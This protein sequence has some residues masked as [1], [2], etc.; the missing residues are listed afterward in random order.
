MLYNR[1]R[2]GEFYIRERNKKNRTTSTGT[3]LLNLDRWSD[4]PNDL[5]ILDLIVIALLRLNTPNALTKK[6]CWSFLFGQ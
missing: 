2:R 4:L 5:N 1:P 6:V 3:K